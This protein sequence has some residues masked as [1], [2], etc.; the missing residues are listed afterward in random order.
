MS[1][2]WYKVVLTRAQVNRYEPSKLYARFMKPFFASRV[3]PDEV[4]VFEK[5]QEGI[6]SWTIYFSPEAAR[7]AQDILDDYSGEPCERPDASQVVLRLGA[8][9]A[10]D[11]LW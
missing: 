9:R 4:A 3:L 6:D 10:K 5:R 2:Q 11:L 1:D 8:D 7:F